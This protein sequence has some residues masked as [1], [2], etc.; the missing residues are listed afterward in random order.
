MQSTL[1]GLFMKRK[2]IGVGNSLNFRAGLV[3]IGNIMLYYSFFADIN[4]LNTRLSDLRKV[5]VFLNTARGK[6]LYKSV[7]PLLAI[8]ICYTAQL[9]TTHAKG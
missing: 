8:E 2:H 5:V 3:H 1:Q 4:R 9:I 7:I 6:L